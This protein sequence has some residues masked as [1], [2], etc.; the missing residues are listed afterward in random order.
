MISLLK[1]QKIF[2]NY[3]LG[4]SGLNPGIAGSDTL[5]KGHGKPLGVPERA[6]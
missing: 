3:E 6:I 2:F 5:L 1:S 4:V